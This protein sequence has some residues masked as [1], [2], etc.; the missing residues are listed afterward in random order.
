MFDRILIKSE[1]RSAER[2]LSIRDIVDMMFYYG[3]VHVVVSQF[4]LGQLLQVFGEDVLYELIT[5]K[6]LFVHP[7]DQHIGAV[8]QN[9]LC[10]AGMFRHNYDSIEQL[11]Y[12]YHRQFKKNSTDN[13]R[14]ASKFSKILVEYR[15]PQLVQESIYKDIENDTFLSKATQ[16]FIKQYYPTYH[17]HDEIV[18]H[19]ETHPSQLEG[20][21]KIVGNIRTDEINEIHVKQG[22]RGTFSYANV[23]LAIGETAQDCY[24]SSELE[25]DLI[26]NNRW[27]ETY[28]LRVIKCIENAENNNRN[29]DCFH[30]T[31][32]F[33]F[34]SP[35]EA[36]VYKTIK[37]IE[38]LKLLD[39]KD[40]VRFKEW[41]K[42]IPNGS[43]L[44]GEFYNRIRKLN[45]DKLWVKGFRVLSQIA[46]GFVSLAAG[47]IATTVDGFVCDKIINGWNPKIFV[48]NIL[49]NNKLLKGTST[50]ENDYGN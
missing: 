38:L 48:D 24:L 34:L 49:R 9:G 4:E 21:Y 13:M 6:R 14:F 25:S 18:L 46:L 40:S 32:A 10:S 41:L 42:T 33:E 26:T 1:S 12:M 8:M 44:P 23:M 36:F 22:Y 28:K 17:N 2:L 27:A 39:Q 20:M 50:D 15:Y 31:V 37:P 19:A 29:I 16:T 35:G 45:S 5:S 11:L 30:Q 3:E 47:A 7:C 43:T